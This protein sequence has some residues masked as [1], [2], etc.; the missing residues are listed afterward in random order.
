MRKAQGARREGAPGRPRALLRRCLDA[1]PFEAVA[2]QGRCETAWL[3]EE[4]LRSLV[5]WPRRLGCSGGDEAAQSHQ[6]YMYRDAAE[7]QVHLHFG[8]AQFRTGQHGTVQNITAQHR[9]EHHITA[10]HRTEHHGTVQN[11][12]SQHRPPRE[13][14][15]DGWEI[16]C[17]LCQLLSS[18]RIA[19]L[20][21]LVENQSIKEHEGGMHP[22]W[23]AV[24]PTY[25]CPH[26]FLLRTQPFRIAST[27]LHRLRAG[28]LFAPAPLV[29]ARACRGFGVHRRNVAD[30]PFLWRMAYPEKPGKGNVDA[31][32]FL[33]SSAVVSIALL[34]EAQGP[35]SAPLIV[36]LVVPATPHALPPPH[37][38]S[39]PPGP[40]RRSSFH[41]GRRHL[42]GPPRNVDGEFGRRPQHAISEKRVARR[43]ALGNAPTCLGS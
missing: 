1:S 42:L 29:A 24:D 33:P 15:E 36:L 38:S 12:T 21:V 28:H 37:A 31:A 23:R 18:K 40:N 7:A 19:K 9:T 14:A 35:L 27:Q 20:P 3:G 4:A 17:E 6:T 39:T 43:S 25:F 10:Q 22:S 16:T 26:P 32:V 41:L 13:P 2:S 34:V 30:R 11:V 8:A 5:R